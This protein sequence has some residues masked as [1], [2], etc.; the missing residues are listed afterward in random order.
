MAT[1]DE[2]YKARSTGTRHK[3]FYAVLYSQWQQEAGSKRRT[4]I[5]PM[6]A[7]DLIYCISSRDIAGVWS[8]V[9]LPLVLSRRSDASCLSAALPRLSCLASTLTRPTVS[10]MSFFFTAR[11]RGN[12]MIQETSRRR[13]V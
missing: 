10:R 2:P 7:V 9:A 8:A 13:G 3:V 11:S 4:C 1:S 6:A 5:L 12:T